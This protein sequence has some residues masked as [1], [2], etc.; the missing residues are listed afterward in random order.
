MTIAPTAN[1]EQNLIDNLRAATRSRV[2]LHP[3][4]RRAAVGVAAVIV[5]G[6][7]GYIASNA[8]DRE[9][10]SGFAGLTEKL[11]FASE[12][13]Q[14]IPAASS[15]IEFAGGT[16][17]TYANENKSAGGSATPAAQPG[18][19]FAEEGE[20]EVMAKL[21]QPVAPRRTG[22]ETAD[23]MADRFVQHSLSTGDRVI[24]GKYF[25]AVNTKGGKQGEKMA[26]SF[27]NAPDFNLSSSGDSQGGGGGGGGASHGGWKY[28]PRA[29]GGP[30]ASTPSQKA[31]ESDRK[32]F[33]AP[34]DAKDASGPVPSN[35]E[36]MKALKRRVDPDGVKNLLPKGSLSLDGGTSKEEQQ[37]LIAA[38]HDKLSPP[39]AVVYSY[40]NDAPAEKKP[41]EGYFELGLVEQKT[42]ES[43][44]ASGSLTADTE[45]IEKHAEGEAKE[46]PVLGLKELAVA[47]PA[48]PKPSGEGQ[49]QPTN[50]PAETPAPP[51]QTEP[52]AERKVIRN[53][54]AEFEVDSFDSALMQITKIVHEEGGYV[55]TTDSD[56][57]PNGKVRGT[58]VVRVAPERLDL[59]I[60]KLRA[61]GDLKSQK[62]NAQDIT[63]EYTD[64]ESGLR[65]GRAMESRLLEMI[66]SGKGEIKDLLAAEKELGSWREKIEHLE[67]EIRYYNNLVSMSTLAITLF[68]RDIKTPTAAAESEAVNMGIESEDVE[69]AR[70]DALK[71]IDDAKG[72]IVASDLKKFDA[73]QLAASITADVPPEAG[74]A[75]IDRLKQLGKVARLDI[76]RATTT[77]GGQGAPSGIKVERKETRFIL[78]LYNLANIEPRQ[79]TAM[80]I[81][82]RDV[83]E[84]YR[85]I[86]ARVQKAA[87]RVVVSTLNRQKADQ[88]TGSITFEVK[89]D[90]ADAVLADVRKVGDVMN[91]TANENQDTANT[92]SAKR[93]FSVQ[94]Y[95]LATVAPRETAT[96][97][98]AARSVPEAYRAL[99]ETLGKADARMIG[100]QLNQQ[101]KQN[102]SATLT[103]EIGREN[104]KVFE[105]ALAGGGDVIARNAARSQD[106]T[107][108]VDSK[109]R[110]DV[111]IMSVDAL[112][113]RE[114]TSMVLAAKNVPNAYQALLETLTNS[115]AHMIDSQLNENDKQNVTASLSFEVLRDGLK[116]FNDT[117]SPLGDVVS[118][119]VSRSQDVQNTI[120]FKVRIDM[121]LLAVEN[122]PP[123]ESTTLAAE[124]GD[125]DKALAGVKS[126]VLAAGGRVVN[127]NIA[128]DRAGRIVGRMLI[129]VPLAKSQQVVD[130]VDGS[131]NIRVRETAQN[132]QVPD[133]ALARARFDVT[134][135]NKELIVAADDGL[136]HSIK[137][138]LQTSLGGLLLSLKFVIVGVCLI[139]PWALIGWVGW[140][141]MKKA[142]GKTAKAQ[143]PA[144]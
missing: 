83:E 13:G 69:K 21:R 93:K 98:L 73:G 79:M 48:G 30:S 65:A 4:V 111:T 25:A 46:G 32:R 124:T 70:A 36:V 44:S 123:R 39:P 60:L 57:L 27:D 125:V 114:S 117:L 64:L 88:T 110:V 96:I 37:R 104:L 47:D 61:L 26:P 95:S 142:M 87:G 40:K 29:G 28:D 112:R 45:H 127:S 101:D 144:A 119:T 92:T 18:G 67:G 52:V 42:K 94:L 56:K 121:N 143:A 68:E 8:M 1:F 81:A 2:W 113:P 138:G 129:D 118:K 109:L 3:A 90:E 23:D 66:K 136:W 86:V 41:T 35:Q 51:P 122:L 135:S 100:S 75:L 97:Q 24:S 89:S 107:N 19:V 34:E 130:K 20:P 120:D 74:G 71:A 14:R 85:T 7:F 55:S 106:T 102:V 108:T 133:G 22:A 82:A 5:L 137:G 15:N 84:A 9:G 72:R 76:N 105:D 38:Q 62:V 78:S 6:G 12:D 53:G 139:L 91:L 116:A 126:T 54:T 31:R 132:Q 77:Q 131:G 10:V 103:F 134:F 80:N 115:G 140:K 33:D 17:L 58:I 49:P 141:W 128:R 11:P 16:Q 50:A 99:T 59:L 43:P 63:K